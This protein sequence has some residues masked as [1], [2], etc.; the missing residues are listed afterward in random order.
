MG[1]EDRKCRDASGRG[2]DVALEEHGAE[3]EASPEDV[4]R[5]IDLMARWALR[6]GWKGG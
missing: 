3:T 4:K 5:V 1:G 6:R 2:P